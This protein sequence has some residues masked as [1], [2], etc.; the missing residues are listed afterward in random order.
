M[1]A[2]R[3]RGRLQEARNCDGPPDSALFACPPPFWRASAMRHLLAERCDEG[4]FFV[5]VTPQLDRLEP[6][7]KVRRRYPRWCADHLPRHLRA[8]P[9][10]LDSDPPPESDGALEAGRFTTSFEGF[11]RLTPSKLRTKFRMTVAFFVSPELAKTKCPLSF[12]IPTAHLSFR[13][14]KC[15]AE[16]RHAKRPK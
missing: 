7:R 12:R 13:N 9:G 16:T 11:E 10:S 3:G 4:G 8:Q 6:A 2:Y 1:N 5:T 14:D 15:F